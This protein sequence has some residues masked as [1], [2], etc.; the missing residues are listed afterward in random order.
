MASLL[1]RMK[2]RTSI[3]FSARSITMR[4]PISTRTHGILDYVTAATLAALPSMLGLSE[5]TTRALQMMAIG[6]LGYSMLTD[7]EL[8]LARLIPMKAH[9][10]MDAANGVALR[11]CRSSWKTMTRPRSPFASARG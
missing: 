3:T 11:R 5:R 10:A 6:K 7:N 8:G 4:K 2:T 1:L 9:L